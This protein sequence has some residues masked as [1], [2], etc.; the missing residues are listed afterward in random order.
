MAEAT[1]DAYIGAFA[2]LYGGRDAVYMLDSVGG[3]Y[4]FGAPEATLPI[5]RYY[6][7]DADA[8]ARVFTEL[9]DR[10]NEY[11]HEAER[12]VNEQVDGA[13]EVVHPDWA[14]NV[15][16]KYKLPLT[17]H[18]DHDAVVTPVDID[19]VRYRE[20]LPV[21]DVDDDVLREVREWCEA[22]T[23]VEH[24]DRVADLVAL[25]GP[26]SSRNTEVGRP[27]SMRGSKLNA[28]VSVGRNSADRR[29][30]SAANNV[31]RS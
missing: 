12:R 29:Q 27:L 14:N 15:N 13:E 28:S 9:I 25:S 5:S 21:E 7:D 10:S 22:F 4:I 31:L 3:T 30:P 20:P 19:D 11:L 1:Y 17:L 2:D 6:E 23:A 18:A 24:E 26:T 8:R 16:R